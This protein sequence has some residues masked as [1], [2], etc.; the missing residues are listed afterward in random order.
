MCVCV[1]VYVFVCVFDLGS[2][3]CYVILLRVVRLHTNTKWGDF[4][5]QTIRLGDMSLYQLQMLKV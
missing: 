3:Y 5:C 1:C 2:A 4:Y